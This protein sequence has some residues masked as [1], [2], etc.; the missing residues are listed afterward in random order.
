VV[1][2][3][4]ANLRVLEVHQKVQIKSELKIAHFWA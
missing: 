4:V 2:K 3:K 1:L